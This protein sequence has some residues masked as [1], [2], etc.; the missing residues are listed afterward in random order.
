[1]FTIKIDP[2]WANYYPAYNENNIWHPA[3]S[4]CLSVF[5]PLNSKK[6]DFV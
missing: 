6:E 4:R 2:V 5:S 3:T 1:M